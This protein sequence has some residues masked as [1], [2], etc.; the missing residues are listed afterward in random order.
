MNIL[1]ILTAED[2]GFF[3]FCKI[4]YTIVMKKQTPLNQNRE[5]LQ[6][7]TEAIQSTFSDFGVPIKIVKAIEGY[8]EFHFYLQPEKVVRMKAILTFKDDLRYALG[9]DKVEIQAPIPNQKMVGITVPKEGPFSEFS[10]AEAIKTKEFVNSPALEVPLG[11]DE[12]GEEL[13]IDLAKMPHLLIAGTTGSGKSVLLHSFVNSLLE[14]NSPETVRFI[15]CDP[16]RVELTVYNDL[17][18]LLTEVITDAKKM[19][20][21]LKWAVKEMERRYDILASEKVQNIVQYHDEVYKPSLISEKKVEYQAESLPY[22]IVMIDELADIIQAYPKELEASIVRLTQMSR[23]VGIHLVLATQRPANNVLTATIKANIPSRI[24]LKVASYVDSRMILDENGAETLAG[25][26]DMLFQGLDADRPYR[27]QS[28]YLS[29]GEVV[30]RVKRI[31]KEQHVDLFTL[32]LDPGPDRFFGKV[33]EMLDDDL[34]EDAK[35]AVIDAGKAST[36]YLQRKLRVGYSRAAQLMDLLEESGVIGPQVGSEPR[37]VI[38][39]E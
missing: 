30:A 39:E 23:A 26:G 17:P 34:Y 15:L 33:E 4:V 21:A 1:M 22:I 12:F 20:M 3:F 8:R 35:Q 27:L 16:K 29:D 24:A 31:K 18:E 36:S 13:S 10:W 14:K 2:G 25:R 5:V 7:M 38:E 11:V 19:V 6:E 28:Y 9:S 32:D 37:K